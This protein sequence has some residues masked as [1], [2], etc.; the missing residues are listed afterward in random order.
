MARF[1]RRSKG[2]RRLGGGGGGLLGTAG[3]MP[4]IFG[5]VAMLIALITF[6]IALSNFDTTYTAVSGYSWMTGLTSV[7]GPFPMV[8]FLAF[9]VA[10]L[11]GI[12]Y[13]AYQNFKMASAGGWTNVFYGFVMS[14][15]SVVIMLILF[16]IIATQLNTTGVAINATTNIASFV[17]LYSIS[18][19][20]PLVVFVT[21]IGAALAP[22]AGV[23]YMAVQAVRSRQSA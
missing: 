23:G 9:M 18:T 22:L 1:R 12:G 14:A 10:G 3:F 16:G 7:M 20:W 15:V 4:T 21:M 6:G 2:K 5:A 17:G 13:G 8:I 19:I 11:S